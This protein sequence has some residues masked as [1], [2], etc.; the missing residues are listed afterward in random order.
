MST[1][2]PT[3]DIHFSQALPVT[4]GGQRLDSALAKLCEQ[5]SRSQLQSWIKTGQVTVDGRRCRPK[6][7]L[8]G[9]EWIVIAAQQE[10]HVPLAPEALPISVVYEDDSLLVVNKSSDLVVHPAA[11]NWQGTLQNALLYHCPDLQFLP[12]AG[13]VHRLDKDTTGLLVVAKTLEAHHH[14][15][16]QLQ[17]RLF[18]REYLALVRGEVIA[19][20]T[21]D[22]PLGRHPVERKRFAVR[23]DGK[24]AMTHYRVEQ[25]LG[26]FTLLRVRLETGRTHQIRV[27]L[28]HLRLPLVGDPLYGG[29]FSLPPQGSA[30]LEA[31]L[32]AFTR[33]ALH[34]ETLGLT[35]PET[36]QSCHWQQ[37]LPD[38]MADLLATLRDHYHD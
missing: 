23:A 9:G 32:R 19:G 10:T 20:G 38:D 24:P 4:L 8:H 27:H 7:I 11:G 6:D 33:Q 5:F 22:Q 3:I 31:C 26:P 30:E 35:H 13:I 21:I 29:R 25:R 2:K 12:R 14:L 15:V 28:A 16:E 37:A 18:Q 1:D 17:Q 36:G 34:A